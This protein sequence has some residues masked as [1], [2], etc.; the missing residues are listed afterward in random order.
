MWIRVAIDKSAI[1]QGAG[2]SPYIDGNQMEEFYFDKVIAEKLEADG[3]LTA[4]WKECD[5][6]FDWGDCDFFYPDKCRIMADWLIRKLS[7]QTEEDLRQIYEKMLEYAQKA[8][9]HCT[10][11]Y[12]D[13]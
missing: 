6:V 10:G 3:F 8:V 2:G 7:G 1:K 13:F 11:L 4:M 9:K 12:F 5:A